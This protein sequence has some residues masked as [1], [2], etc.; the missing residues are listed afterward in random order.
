M[1]E[2]LYKIGQ[3]TGRAPIIKKLGAISFGMEQ[4]PFVYK[5]ELWFAESKTPDKACNRQY[6]RIRNM[7]SGWI[8]EPFG[9]DYY[10]ASA[11][12]END[13]IYVFAT[14]RV[15]D[16]PL[17]MYDEKA[18][19]HDPRGGHTVRMFVTDDLTNWEIKD[20]ITVPGRRLWNTSVCKGKDG[21]VMAI[22][23]RENEGCKD[24]AV[25]VGFT[26]FFAKSSDLVNWEM[27]PDEC[28]YTKDRYNACPAIRYESGWYYMIC[29]EALPAGRYASYIYRS[30]NFIDWEVGFHNPIMM[31][32]D[33]DRVAKEGIEFSEEEIKLLETGLN[34][35]SSDMDLCE[36]EG[37]THI[38]YANGD[39]QTYSFV[40]E[41]IYDGKLCDFLE[42]FFR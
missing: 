40:C 18:E 29:L 16:K 2:F 9:Q 26:S 39:Q 7:K 33:E 36:F 10:F 22:E 3:K 20:I 19:W 23:V 4:T 8:S 11:Y 34:I 32:N 41:A 35:N 21:Y 6:I 38:F 27:M 14:S 13:K 28:S 30:K 24:P 1:S 5:N 42:R 15:D 37:K 12:S 31:Y 17:T 25:G